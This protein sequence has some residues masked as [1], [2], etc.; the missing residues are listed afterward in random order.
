M[1][2]RINPSPVLNAPPA[3][4]SDP[5]L[6]V[7]YSSAVTALQAKHI[8]KR[9]VSAAFS[10]SSRPSQRCFQPSLLLLPMCDFGP[11]PFLESFDLGL[12]VR[13]V[14]FVLPTSGIQGAL[15]L[16]DRSL[17]SLSFLLLGGLFRAFGAPGL[18][19][20]LLCRPILEVP[21]YPPFPCSPL[22]AFRTTDT[23]FGHPSAANIWNGRF[24]PTSGHSITVH[25]ANKQCRRQIE[26]SPLAQ[27]EMSLSTVLVGEFWA[28]DGDFDEPDGDRPD[29]RVA[30][31]SCKQ[32][33]SNG[34]HDADEPW[35]A[36][37]VPTGQGL[38][39]AGPGGVGFPEARP[40]EPSR[41][42]PGFTRYCHWHH[43][44]ALTGLL[45]DTVR[46]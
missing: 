28:D 12:D 19:H 37:G 31:S 26:K 41:L 15:R 5:F 18:R 35:S 24:A 3:K 43:S 11:R 17:P 7:G 39:S 30:G 2:G 20:A 38:R 10:P 44:G 33:Q 16:G 4:E 34:S 21:R 9:R 36:S 40:A 23:V 32:D 45:A 8:S 27:I 1:E 29:E 42:P 13:S 14:L 25:Y 22:M 46:A 6:H